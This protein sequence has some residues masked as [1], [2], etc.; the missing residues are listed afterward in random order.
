VASEHIARQ[1]GAFS[2]EN[3]ALRTLAHNLRAVATL[4]ER[5]N[6]VLD[7]I[8][9]GELRVHLVQDQQAKQLETL[10]GSAYIVS[11]GLITASLVVGSSLIFVSD[12]GPHYGGLPLIG[13]GGFVLSGVFAAWVLWKMI[14]GRT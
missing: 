7:Q 10:K 14:R 11:I 5:A 3:P 9:R 4:P 6:R 13:L 12:I 1:S 8:E 2:M